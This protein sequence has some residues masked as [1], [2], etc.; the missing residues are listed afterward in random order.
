MAALAIAAVGAKAV[1][2]TVST[3]AAV[4]AKAAA[5]TVVMRA[6]LAMGPPIEWL[7]T[8]SLIFM[9][10]DILAAAAQLAAQLDGDGTP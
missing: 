6:T 5:K 4:K 7:P 2:V 8:L 1:V 10:V 3:A 9:G